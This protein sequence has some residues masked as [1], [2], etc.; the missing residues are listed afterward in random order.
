MMMADHDI[1]TN[2]LF[3]GEFTMVAREHT[4]QDHMENCA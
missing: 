2:A 3:E 1:I 4:S